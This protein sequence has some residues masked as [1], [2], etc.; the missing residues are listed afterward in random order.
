MS[1]SLLA[2]PEGH[3]ST[4]HRQTPR[5]SVSWATVVVCAVV[6]AA[7]DGY[8]STSLRG[9]VGAIEVSQSPFR[10]WMRDSTLMLPLFVLAVLAGLA[11]TRRWVGRSHRELVQLSVAA[12]LIIVLTSAVSIG[13]VATTSAYD[14]NIQA[15]QL[16]Q[17]H[18]SHIT[19]TFVDPGAVIP[20]TTGTCTGLC[21]ARH[22][23]LTA[24]VR[25]V[26]YASVVILITNLVLVAWVLALRGGRL[27]AP[28]LEEPELDDEITQAPVGAVLT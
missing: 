6:I 10:S 5:L 26:G 16:G 2:P 9:A 12:L 18:K 13:G 20:S 21:S 24:H 14:Y 11:L 28:H 17:I 1:I 22:A 19:T 8:W 4:A 3:G 25:A 15:S 7:V 27:W 23:T